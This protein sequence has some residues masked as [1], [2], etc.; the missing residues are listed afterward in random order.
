M[1]QLAKTDSTP[2]GRINGVA[3]EGLLRAVPQIL[4]AAIADRRPVWEVGV[5]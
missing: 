1:R 4:V 3:P 5:P 2:I